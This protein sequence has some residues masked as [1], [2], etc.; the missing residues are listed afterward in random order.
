MS[1]TGYQT[2]RTVGKSKKN[3]IISGNL[4]QAPYR[5]SEQGS[6]SQD[7]LHLDDFVRWVNCEATLFYGV[8][9]NLDL[10]ARLNSEFMAGL[11][12]KWQLIGGKNSAAAFAIGSEFGILALD[13]LY[14][15]LPLYFSVHP[16]KNFTFYISP[17]YS[18]EWN[19]NH[20]FS[21]EN[22]KYLG[23][24]AG[25]V[26][27]SKQKTT[28]DFGLFRSHRYDSLE[29]GEDSVQVKVLPKIGIGLSYRF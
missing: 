7:T 23:F 9:E 14:Y 3:L 16:N 21:K 6:F 17:K 10:G 13:R 2:G 19:L 15:Q 8:G 26:L 22:I 24:N 5:Y 20:Y 4:Y 29:F 27:G 11:I 12:A 25:V 28:V 1:L 18:Y